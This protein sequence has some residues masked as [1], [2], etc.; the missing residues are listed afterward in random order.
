MNRQFVI[1]LTLGAPFLL[2]GGIML[3]LILRR[4]KISRRLMREAAAASRIRKR[5]FF[6]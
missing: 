3:F 4:R 5:G 2:I 1:F 6:E